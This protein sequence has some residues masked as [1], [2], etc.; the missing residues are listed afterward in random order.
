MNFVVACRL[1]RHV[2][3]QT[4]ENWKNVAVDGGLLAFVFTFVGFAAV[5]EAN[6]QR[7]PVP[8]A[9]M[10]TDKFIF[11]ILFASE[12]RW[13]RSGTVVFFVHVFFKFRDKTFFA[14]IPLPATKSQT[15]TFLFA[16]KIFVVG[17]VMSGVGKGIATSVNI[18][19]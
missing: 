6:A 10:M 9:A 7:G 15:V 16:A 13:N 8:F 4:L 11:V 12:K 18:T 17:G 5:A 14:N 3:E 1:K 19:N 2:T